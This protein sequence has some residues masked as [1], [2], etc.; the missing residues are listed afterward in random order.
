MNDSNAPLIG[1]FS[2]PPGNA[3]REVPSLPRKQEAEAPEGVDADAVVE[4]MEKGAEQLRT[5]TPEEKAKEYKERLKELGITD[6][7]A[8]GILEKVLV[9]GYYEEVVRIGPLPVGVR[10]RNYKDVKRALDFLEVEKPTYPMGINDIIAKYNMAASLSKYGDTTFKFPSRKAGNTNEEIEEA[11]DE[12]YSFVMELPTVAV[13]RLMQIIH[14][15]DEKV[16]AVFAE[17]APEDF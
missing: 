14:D 7:V 16:A 8:R 1:K 17:G 10:T 2:G 6:V 3:P 11:F 5:K 9:Q 4:G 12:R 13:D 15:F